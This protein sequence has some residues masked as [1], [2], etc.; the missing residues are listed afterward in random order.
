MFHTEM[1]LPNAWYYI[2]FIANFYTLEHV[3]FLK[4]LWTISV[5]EQFYLVWGLCLRFFYK[6][7]ML[8][9]FLL[10]LA[11]VSFSVF[12]IINGIESYF[13]TV[14]YLFDFAFGGL[15]AVLI[16]K[17]KKINWLKNLSGVG[18]FTFYGYLVFHFTFFYFLDKNATGAANG[19]VALVSRYLFIIYIALLIAEQM[20]N[21]CRMQLLEKSRFLIFTGKLSYGLYCFHG[22]TIT[23][24]NLL[25]ARFGISN[26]IMVIIYFAINYLIAS[27][28]YFYLESPFL[29]LKAKWRRA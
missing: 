23:F 25:L 20:I 1:S 3:F 29:K 7:L 28:S 2:F 24:V 9:I 22:I 11:S 10:I 14:T 13:N 15:A 27:I 26:W 21:V 12:A 17:N 8:V 19:L 16:F 18:R 4:F 6:R 5:E